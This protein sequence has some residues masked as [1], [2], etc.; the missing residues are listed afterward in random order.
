MAFT[1]MEKIKI[2]LYLG[3]NDLYAQFN[4]YLES[5]IAQADQDADRVTLIR[6]MLAKIEETDLIVQDSIENA[7]L[8]RLEDIEFYP[9]GQQLAYMNKQGM[10]LTKRLAIIIGVAKFSEYFNSKDFPGA[11]KA[12]SGV[13]G[14]VEIG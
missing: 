11:G 2:R 5:A 3:Y 9:D 7:G 4:S 12:Y 6:D 1:N 8:K 13:S 14:Y 10:I